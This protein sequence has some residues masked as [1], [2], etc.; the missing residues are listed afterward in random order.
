MPQSP[1]L[2]RYQRLSNLRLQH[3]PGLHPCQSL[4]Q[5]QSLSHQIAISSTLHHG[6]SSATCPIVQLPIG[7]Y[8]LYVTASPL[9]DATNCAINGTSLSHIAQLAVGLY[10]ATPFNDATH[11]AID[12][13]RLSLIA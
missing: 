11:F 2:H 7:L 10:A 1:D 9:S 12:G 6:P 3:V 13:T 8:D 4:S 5:S